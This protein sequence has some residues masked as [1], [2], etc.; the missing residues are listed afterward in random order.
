M[1]ISLCLFSFV[2]MF[3]FKKDHER[4]LDELRCCIVLYWDILAKQMWDEIRGREKHKM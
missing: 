2:M 1:Y 3:T 4:V